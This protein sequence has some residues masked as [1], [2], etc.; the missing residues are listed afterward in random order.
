MLSC[1]E[2][3]ELATAYAEGKLPWA[4]RL[5]FLMHLSMCKHC[6]LYVKQLKLTVKAVGSLPRP[7]EPPAPE[8]RAALLRQFESW[9]TKP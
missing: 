4:D 6:R 7:V 9:K 1:R 3:T 2:I 8:V 5:R